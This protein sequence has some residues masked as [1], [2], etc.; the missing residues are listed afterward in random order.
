MN[1]LNR[2]PAF[3]A[4]ALFAGCSSFHEKWDAA[5]RPGQLARA[6]RWEGRWTSAYH[7]T[8]AGTPEGGR[9]R[10]VIE[11]VSEARI[12]AHFHANWLAFSADYSVPFDAQISRSGKSGAP[13]DF[14][15]RHE[16]PKVFGGVYRYDAR[17]S[18]DRFM[19]RYGSS[20]DAGTFAMTR[21]LTNAALFH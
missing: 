12:L 5:G 16:L 4:L 21:L 11:P 6:S 2:L 15:G 20:Y 17:I 10:C 8:P 19:A 7:K 9:L 1:T 18:G 14:R 13:V 3:L